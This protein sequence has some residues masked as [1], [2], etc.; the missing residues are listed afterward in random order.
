MEKENTDC[1]SKFYKLLNNNDV[2]TVLGLPADS[3]KVCNLW[4]SHHGDGKHN[5][6][7]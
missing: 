5:L 4:T 7:S 3:R 1:N 6:S 2:F